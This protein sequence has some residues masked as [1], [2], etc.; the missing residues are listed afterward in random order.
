MCDVV[1]VVIGVGALL[2]AYSKYEESRAEAAQLDQQAALLN[3]QA[4]D[5]RLRGQA[6]SGM[7]KAETSQMIETQEVQFA[8]AGVDP[9]FGTPV[10]VYGSTRG[11]GELRSAD[12]ENQAAREAWGYEQNAVMAKYAA[13][14]KRKAGNIA[15]ATSLIGG[16]AGVAYGLGSSAPLATS[17][18]SRLGPGLATSTPSLGP[19]GLITMP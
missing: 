17:A 3:L 8:N 9:N 13:R 14:A 2:T 16:A 6:Q 1:S 5:A 4:G 11:I 19:V 10:D 15:V 12:I 7:A 18:P